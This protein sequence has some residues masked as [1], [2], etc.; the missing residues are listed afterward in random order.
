M[1]LGSMG[2]KLN[3]YQIELPPVMNYKKSGLRGWNSTANKAL[4]GDQISAKNKLFDMNMFQSNQSEH[5]N[6]MHHLNKQNYE[7][8]TVANEKFVTSLSQHA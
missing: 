5:F 4:K 1:S 2:S 3:Q 8:T 7:I 6:S